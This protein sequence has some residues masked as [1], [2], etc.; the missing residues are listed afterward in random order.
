MMKFPDAPNFNFLKDEIKNAHLIRLRA[1]IAPILSVELLPYFTDH[2]V[3]HSD[4]L[5]GIISKL[6]EPMGTF[7]GRLTD[8]ELLIVYAACYL[9]DLG[10][11]YENLTQIKVIKDICKDVT[12]DE[13]E[14]KTRREILR[15]YHHQ[16]SAELIMAATGPASP[17]GFQIG[18]EYNPDYVAALCEAHGIDT[19]DDKYAQLCDSGGTIR[20]NLLSA[21]LR[22]ADILDETNERAN[23]VKS[24]ALKL[25]LDSQVHWWRHYYVEALKWDQMAVTICFNFPAKRKE[26]YSRIIPQV[27]IPELR[28]ELARHRQV[29]STVKLNWAIEYTVLNKSYSSAEEMP[30]SVLFEM[31]RIIYERK[32]IE[33]EE[34][35]MMVLR[36]FREAQPFIERQLNNIQQKRTSISQREY[37]KELYAVSKRF[38][39]IGSNRNAWII[40]LPDFERIYSS[41]Q[42]DEQIEIG[43]WLSTK[44]N[45]DN[46]YK[47]AFDVLRIINPLLEPIADVK[48]W[49]KNLIRQK[50]HALLYL[51]VYKET[52]ELLS[53]AK[54]YY[55]PQDEYEA[56]ENGLY[57]FH[58]NLTDIPETT[59]D[60]EIILSPASL[61]KL[62]ISAIKDAMAGN[63]GRAVITLNKWASSGTSDYDLCQLK[64]VESYIK[65]LAGEDDKCLEI[66]ETS[67]HPLLDQL[68]DNLRYTVEDNEASVATQNIIQGSILKRYAL[69]DQERIGQFKGPMWNSLLHAE[70]AAQKGEHFEAYRIYW[71]NLIDAFESANWRWQQDSYERMSRE[72]LMLSYYASASYYAILAHSQDMSVE[73][74]KAFLNRRERVEI[75]ATVEF[76]CTSC[77]PMRLAV[78]AC[79]M[80]N[81]MSDA[82]PDD[83]LNMVVSWLIPL[84]NT[85]PKA[86]MHPSR[87]L[88]VN[89]WEAMASLVWRL[90]STMA[91]KV[92]SSAINH[93][94]WNS[95]TPDRKYL[96]EAVYRLVSRLSPKEVISLGNAAIPLATTR[97]TDY[98]FRETIN[99]LCAIIEKEP[100]LKDVVGSALYPADR[101]KISTILIRTAKVFGK[102]DFG[103]NKAAILYKAVM[104]NLG[105]MVQRLPKDAIVAQSFDSFGSITAKQSEN[106]QTIV[107]MY[108]GLSLN[109]LV[110]LRGELNQDQVAKLVDLIVDLLNDTDN[111][112]SNK[113]ILIEE[114]SELP[115]VL[116]KQLAEK[117]ILSILSIAKGNIKEGA[118]AMTYSESRNPMNPFK[119][120]DTSPY[121]LQGIAILCLSKILRVHND[122]CR[123]QIIDVLAQ[124]LANSNETVRMYAYAAASRIPSLTEELMSGLLVGTRDTNDRAATAAF[125]AIAAMKEAALSNANWSMV[126]LSISLGTHSSL[127]KLR[128][129]AAILLSKNWDRFPDNVQIQ[130]TEARNFIETDPCYSVRYAFKHP[131]E[132][133][134]ND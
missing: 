114:L 43:I 6:I 18:Q 25:D 22:V 46:H 95:R 105:T 24:H 54:K 4:S 97:K 49:K 88:F 59:P 23:R 71:R 61:R 9:H 91:E 28:K 2:S 81:A 113:Y 5:V 116:T 64:L 29:L 103:K 125:S 53:E 45:D 57:F 41:L 14:E 73:V 12:W 131:E 60:G 133:R 123:K 112:F 111:T 67:L 37:L 11:H 94:F 107:Q 34:Q 51:G 20:L 36:S 122:I 8:D 26:E 48:D 56:I 106:S 84:C 109:T 42:H 110:S 55:S 132:L 27:Q 87:S 16:I 72:C 21:L 79:K 120:N 74:G 82:L 101:G 118:V 7:S 104:D 58:G 69:Q 3:Y 134:T 85:V 127:P 33:A 39:D 90:D 75:D 1:S 68:P 115:N 76:I 32:K 98:D 80:I 38:S 30:E 62:K 96:I 86:M 63:A 89:S 129:L 52:I 92:L 17:I 50:I 40:L 78:A 31:N 130:L 83:R 13:L 77:Y 117:V 44:L 10:M 126:A 121:D 124:C 128:Q 99:L 70:K 35:R 15:K 102:E 100:S 47:E 19:M 66:F 119:L 108:S 65:Y 93:S